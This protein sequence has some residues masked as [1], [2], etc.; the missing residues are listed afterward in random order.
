MR[1]VAAIL[2]VLVASVYLIFAACERKV[3]VENGGFADQV[4]CFVC[5]GDNDALIVSAQQ[6]WR[7][8]VHG[9]GANVD[10]TNRSSCP[11]CHD[12]QGFL[13]FLATGEVN[14]PYENVT[15]IHCFT[16]H[17]PHTTGTL[18]FRADGPYQL[19]NGETFD[20]G[21]GNVCANCHHSRFDVGEITDDFD[22]GSTR[23]YSH[24]GPQADLIEGT[25]GYEMDGYLYRE[26]THKNAVEGACVGCHMS[27]P[28]T[29]EGYKIGGHT[30]NMEDEETG[31]NLYE[32]CVECHAGAEESEDYDFM[33]N[34][35]YDYDGVIEGYQTEV[36]G[37][38]DSL[39]V[40]LM[41]EGVMNANH[42]PI[43]QVIADADVAGALHNYGMIEEDRSH[44][45]HNFKYIVSLL[46]NS[47][48]YLD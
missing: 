43:P 15:A 33:A 17:A 30:W 44:G 4:E 23:Y 22:W 32:L 16:C 13:E 18:D 38:L 1:K 26:S 24:H 8:S 45:V 34:L 2:L 9:S 10:Y 12:H 28:E 35:D 47:I 21:E 31:A 5:H 41:A 37:L 27:N 14:P 25:G 3:V 7:N 19:M 48:D 42:G 20:H 6:E 39:A 36:D 29:H 40:L 46:Q 11:Q